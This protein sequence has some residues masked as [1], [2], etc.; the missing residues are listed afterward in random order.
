MASFAAADAPP[1][2]KVQKNDTA[3]A[4]APAGGAGAEAS[5]GS[6]SS[7]S[8]SASS[9]ASNA[10][11]VPQVSFTVIH[12]QK[13]QL[14]C[15]ETMTVVE[16]KKKLEELTGVPW[17]MA[18]LMYRGA[19]QND[20]TLASAKVKNKSKMRL[21]GNSLAAVVAANAKPAAA[22]AGLKNDLDGSKDKASDEPLCEQTR[23]KKILEKGL[24]AGALPACAGHSPVPSDGGRTCLKGLIGNTGKETRLTFRND[25]SQLWVATK[26]HTQKLPYNAVRGQ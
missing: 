25:T 18:K 7:S 6:A 14:T 24:P 26:Q 5:A 22:G 1:P 13:H 21:I 15:P 10:A 2:A 8:S 11:A 9:S 4:A 23:H 17:S 16:L 20:Q 3:G 19:M 12:K